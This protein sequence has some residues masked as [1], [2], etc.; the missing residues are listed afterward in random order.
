MYLGLYALATRSSQDADVI[1][2]ITPFIYPTHN[3][4]EVSSIHI[5]PGST[6]EM[7][8]IRSKDM[9][10]RVL[11]QPEVV[12]QHLPWRREIVVLTSHGVTVLR[13]SKPYELLRD[14]LNERQG[15]EN[16][17]GHYEMSVNKVQPLANSVLLA[18]HPFLLADN[19]VSFV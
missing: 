9:D 6:I 4:T 16:I 1:W 13:A 14:L 19:N 11:E 2:L 15:P 17:K 3:Y 18:T 5:L 10:Q 8:E 7:K 12:T